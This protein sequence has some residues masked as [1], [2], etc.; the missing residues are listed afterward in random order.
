MQWP[1]LIHVINT[2]KNGVNPHANWT[3]TSY[4]LARTESIGTQLAKM[5]FDVGI[6]DEVHYLKTPDSA[7]TRAIFGGG[8]LR[9]FDPIGNGCTRVL[10]LSG[11]PIPNRPREAYTLARGMCFDAIDWLSYDRFAERFNPSR[12]GE[13]INVETGAVSYYN[14]E[15]TGRHAELQNRLRAN[16]MTRHLKRD[17][18][19]QLKLPSYDIVRA[20]ETGPVRAALAAE[21]MLDFDPDTFNSNSSLFGGAIA[22]VRRQM[23]EAL[24]PQV[25][26][27][28]DLLLV[29]GVDKLVI[30]AWHKSVL[31]ILEKGLHKWGVVRVDGNTSSSARL[32]AISEFQQKSFIHVIIGNLLSLGT[33]TD[34]LQ[35]VSSNVV[36]AEPSWVPGENVQAIDRLDRLGQKRTVMADIFVAPRSFSEYILESA[37]R[38][39][40]VLHKSL[41]LIGG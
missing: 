18:L 8:Q 17:V 16:F 21:K 31:D 7:R 41:D 13:R 25:V 5:H 40:Q 15:R 39:G 35:T 10:A 1:Y 19:T 2:A 29:G 32:Q 22:T 11:T 9:Q 3:I 23:G 14:D 34:G 4:D 24:A 36:I 28:A 6:F 27:Y 37:L 38:K 26:T 20:E 12:R 33:G 30:F